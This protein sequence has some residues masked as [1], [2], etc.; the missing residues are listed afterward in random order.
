ME[1]LIGPCKK[2]AE[3]QEGQISLPA[4]AIGPSNTGLASAAK[5][6]EAR[7]SGPRPTDFRDFLGTLAKPEVLWGKGEQ[8]ERSEVCPKSGIHGAQFVLTQSRR[9]IFRLD[10]C[11]RRLVQLLITCSSKSPLLGKYEHLL[12]SYK[13]GSNFASIDFQQTLSSTNSY[14]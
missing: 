7:S 6:A 4:K 10:A 12:N 5:S 11:R 9:T 8:T 1:A 13:L 14:D 3:R 2:L